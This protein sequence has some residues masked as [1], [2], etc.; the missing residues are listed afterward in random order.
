MYGTEK[1]HLFSDRSIY[2]VGESLRFNAFV[3]S[4]SNNEWN[5]NSTILYVELISYTG[6]QEY[7]AKFRIEQHNCSGAF[8]ISDKVATGNYLLRAYTNVMKNG[9]AETYAY[10]SLKIVNARNYAIT[11][12][13]EPYSD[14]EEQ[15]KLEG[16][17]GVNIKPDR[18]VYGFRDSV[19]LTFSI[20]EGFSNLASL[21]LSVVPKGCVPKYLEIQSFNSGIEK[22]DQFVPENIGLSLTGKITDSTMQKMLE[23]VLVSLSILGN[24]NVVLSQFTDEKGAF[25]F[26]IPDNYGSKEMFISVNSKNNERPSIQINNDFSRKRVTIPNPMFELDSIEQ[27]A[28]EQMDLNVQIQNQFGIKNQIEKSATRKNY[29]FYGEP[30]VR[31]VLD[32]YVQL[33]MLEDYLKEFFAHVYVQTKKKKKTISISGNN[34]VRNTYPPLVMIDWLVLGD[35]SELWKVLPKRIKSIEAVHTQFIHGDFTYGGILHIQTVNNDF[36][37]IKLPESGVFF[38]YKLLSPSV[39]LGVDTIPN[40]KSFPDARNTLI[41]IPQVLEHTFPKSTIYV[42]TSDTPGEFVIVLQGITSKGDR[43]VKCANLL[44][45]SK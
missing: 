11:K 42:T 17:F 27:L 44:V 20:D 45:K 30:E 7:G 1:V 19:K 43:F 6:D 12:S 28:V 32:D 4:S 29:S 33:P 40:E 34:N 36:G 35:Y 24:E 13:N 3:Q 37:G 26:A 2:V 38:D 15:E 31:L 8:V 5:T 23:G 39:Q 41:W 14:S 9:G 16:T 21:S 22:E 10:C 18:A 25:Y